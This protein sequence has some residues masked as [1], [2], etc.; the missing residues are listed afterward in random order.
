M[1]CE[2]C[3]LEII[4]K[5][6]YVHDKNCGHWKT[7]EKEL[8]DLFTKHEEFLN[9]FNTLFQCKV[10]TQHI[11][12]FPDINKIV[13]FKLSV[14]DYGGHIKI[15]NGINDEEFQKP[16]VLTLA[17]RWFKTKKWRYKAKCVEYHNTIEKKYKYVISNDRIIKIMPYSLFV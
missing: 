5:L 8:Y 4:E 2:I 3:G 13:L 11:I 1:T 7:N 9:M 15:S 6:S 14:A 16:H 17:N 12:L 10:S